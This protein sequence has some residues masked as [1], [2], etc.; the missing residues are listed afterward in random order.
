MAQPIERKVLLTEVSVLERLVSSIHEYSI[1][2][3]EQ[4]LSTHPF[5]RFP[6]TVEPFPTFLTISTVL[7]TTAGATIPCPKELGNG[8]VEG[9][10]NKLK[11]IKR[12]MYGRA[13][14]PL[15]R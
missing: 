10:V 5:R 13:A 7:A 11:L 4:M 2:K 3:R 12:M 14:F 8:L 1:G 15:L 6:L 9:K